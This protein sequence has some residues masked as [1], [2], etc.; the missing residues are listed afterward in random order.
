MKKS[1][2][3]INGEAPEALPALENYD[4]VACTDG[5]FQTLLDMG[6]KADQ[7]DFISGDF[8]SLPV[9]EASA[10][11]SKLIPTPNQEYPDFHKALE[12][13][14]ERGMTHVDVYGGSGGEMDHFLGNLTAAL[15][16]KNTLKISFYDRYAQYYFLPKKEVIKGVKDR[17]VS[18]YPFPVAEGIQTSGL[19]WELHNETLDLAKRIGTRNVALSD[20]VDIQFTH[21]ELLVFIAHL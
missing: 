19:K 11:Y 3:L 12:L 18:L 7:V 13:L 14:V 16:F 20:E 2:L 21:G 1:L 5:A 17:M 8:D 10:Y 15:Q 4:L 9:G 6:V